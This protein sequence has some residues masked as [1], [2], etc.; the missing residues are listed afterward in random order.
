[1]VAPARASVI[2]NYYFYLRIIYMFNDLYPISTYM[3]QVGPAIVFTHWILVVSKVIVEQGIH[4]LNL[5]VMK[6]LSLGIL[7]NG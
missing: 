3:V 6:Y 5:C 7:G 2:A 1:M 4:Q